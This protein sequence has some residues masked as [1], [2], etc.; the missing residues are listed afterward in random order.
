MVAPIIGGAKH[1][2]ISSWTQRRNV[3]N[4]LPL[5]TI[6][7][8]ALHVDDSGLDL[9]LGLDTVDEPHVF[10]CVCFRP[11]WSITFEFG[12]GFFFS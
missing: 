2:F 10:P 4:I 8:L 12:G 7:F 1:I 11:A 6:R 5:A 9:V 3:G